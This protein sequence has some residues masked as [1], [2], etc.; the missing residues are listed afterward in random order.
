MAIVVFNLGCPQTKKDEKR[1][2]SAVFAR[3]AGRQGLR[4]PRPDLVL[5][6]SPPLATTRPAYS[7][8]C[9]YEVPLIM[10]IREIETGYLDLE[11]SLLK[12]IFISP[13]HRT[14]LK[15]YDRA[16]SIIATSPGIAMTAAEITSTGKT[17]HVLP[18]ELD[19]ETLFQEFNKI[20]TAIQL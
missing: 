3:R 18:D 7:L 12:K 20:L 9:F 8:S 15:A 19:F 13:V 11:N 6:S 17:I 5:A 16:E 2:V 10:E 14:A 4:L 1:S